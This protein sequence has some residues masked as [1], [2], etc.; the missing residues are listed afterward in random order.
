M[1]NLIELQEFYDKLERFDWYY[2]WSDDGK[3]YRKGQEEARKLSREASGDPGKLDLYK[4]FKEYVSSGPAFNTEQKPKPER[5][6]GPKPRL[7]GP[8]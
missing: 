7:D 6:G 2:E 1:D 5:P 4:A 3:V 8:F